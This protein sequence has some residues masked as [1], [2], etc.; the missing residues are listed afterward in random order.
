M[1]EMCNEISELL[2][3]Y[4]D[5]VLSPEEETALRAHLDICRDCRD[6]LELMKEIHSIAPDLSETA[7]SDLIP[8]VMQAVRAGE[9][10]N[11]RFSL[12]NFRCLAFIKIF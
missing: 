5:G 11:K 1:N 2:S 6:R 3:G 12:S 8:K 10:K 9:K 7:P 4:I